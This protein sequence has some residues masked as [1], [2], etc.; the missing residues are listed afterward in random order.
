MIRPGEY[1]DTLRALGRFLD[2]AQAYGVE[3]VDH[4][5][6]WTVTWDH[7]ATTPFRDIELEALRAAAREHRGREGDLPRFTT[8]QMLRSLGD[9]LDGMNAT[10]F[11]IQEVAD[12]YRLTAV[13]EG[14][15]SVQTYS[16]EEL[17]SLVAKR[18]ESR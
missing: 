4:G 3:I 12:G 1:S 5:E 17:R 13:A 10:T 7:A 2:D 18:L 8:S 16:L 6:E 11:T 9:I 14:R 15:E